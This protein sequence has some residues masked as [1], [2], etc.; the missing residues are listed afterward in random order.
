MLC[1]LFCILCIVKML[2]KYTVQFGTI[3]HIEH[4]QQWGDRISP[5]L[6]FKFF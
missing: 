1:C 3:T 5:S 2:F 6:G 4:S